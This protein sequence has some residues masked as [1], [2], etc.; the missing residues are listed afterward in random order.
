MAMVLLRRYHRDVRSPI[1]AGGV[2]RGQ[3]N[4]VQPILRGLRKIVLLPHSPSVQFFHHPRK[5]GDKEFLPDLLSMDFARWAEQAS[6][7][8][9][10]FNLTD[11]RFGLQRIEK[12]GEEY[13]I[14]RGRSRVPGIHQDFGP[15]YLSVDEEHSLA[16]LDKTQN[17]LDTLGD[18]ERKVLE[19]IRPLKQFGV[20]E[21]RRATH[22]DVSDKTIRRALKNG[23]AFGMLEMIGPGRYGWVKLENDSASCTTAPREIEEQVL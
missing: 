11:V 4:I 18:K 13:T 1:L 14:F 12:G 22:G 3:V 16:F 7:S 15:F 20:P 8:R 5:T 9:I 2:F 10:L 17:V 21:A 19:A 23:C 6:G